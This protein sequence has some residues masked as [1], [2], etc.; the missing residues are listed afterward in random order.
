MRERLTTAAVSVLMVLGVG[1]AAS[2]PPPDALAK[3]MKDLGA[4]VTDVRA[5]VGAKDYAGLAKAA[6]TLQALLKTNGAFWQQRKSD[7]ALAQNQIAVKAAADL[8]AAAKSKNDD[9]LLAA[10]KALTGS[11][12]ACHTAHRER[13]PD[14]KYAIK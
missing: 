6:T 14:G 11:C 9:G 8:L 5:G 2:E 12:G 3:T 4:A 13:T 1:L 7:D 10:Q